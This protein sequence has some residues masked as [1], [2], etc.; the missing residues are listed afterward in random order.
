MLKP[1]EKN[2]IT[3]GTKEWCDTNVNI[4]SGCSNNCLYCYAKK[5]AIRF[6]RKTETTWKKMELNKKAFQK[7]Y[8]K[9]SGRIMF[10]TSH[11]I[12]PETV[13]NCI[14]VLKKLLRAGNEVLITT[15]PSLM[16]MHILVLSLQKFKNQIQFRFTIT[17]NNDLTLGKWES[18]APRFL[19]RLTA[20]RL[21]FNEGS[22]NNENR[23]INGYTI[24][25][26][27]FNKI[28][29]TEFDRLKIL[30]GR[31]E[32]RRC[33]C[34]TKCVQQIVLF[35]DDEARES[36]NIWNFNTLRKG[37]IYWKGNCED[38]GLIFS[39]AD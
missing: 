1:K 15:K 27:I 14:I 24:D 23:W 2:K 32:R 33:D 13:K 6:K 28:Y 31:T 35:N 11:D 10:P 12:T 29:R 22:T 7:G 9:R 4:Y 39:E 17:S 38:C 21:V 25:R 19:E 26:E 37:N 36:E 5:M 30:I 20:L 18:G 16:C 34:G 3:S 8:R